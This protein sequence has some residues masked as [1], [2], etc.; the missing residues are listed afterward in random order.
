MVLWALFVSNRHTFPVFL[1][2]IGIN[3]LFNSILDFTILSDFKMNVIIWHWFI[4]P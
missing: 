3:I 4:I 1:E 2:G